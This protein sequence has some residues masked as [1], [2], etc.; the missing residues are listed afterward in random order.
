M[1]RS[2]VKPGTVL[3][4]INI[5]AGKPEIV[6]KPD[7]EYPDW[8]MKFLEPAQKDFTLEQKLSAKYIRLENRA[9]IKAVALAKK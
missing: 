3:K 5:F 1:F 9:K 8:L 7:A 2:S 6:A 4:G